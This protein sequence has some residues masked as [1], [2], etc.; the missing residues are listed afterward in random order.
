MSEYKIALQVQQAYTKELLEKQGKNM[1]LK[2]ENANFNE[3][4]TLSRMDEALKKV[5]MLKL[6]AKQN[7]QQVAVS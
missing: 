4:L 5:F 1:F 3:V 2:V 7:A 6:R